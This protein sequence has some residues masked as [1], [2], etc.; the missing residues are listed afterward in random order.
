MTIDR[1]EFDSLS[2]SDLEELTEAQVP[3]GLRLEYKRELYGN[4]DSDKREFLKDVTALAN[5][6]GGH[7]ILG[8]EEK[9]I[10]FSFN[11]CAEFLKT[12]SGLTKCSRTSP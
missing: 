7:L 6:H 10:P 4:S 5:S 9:I 12:S 1:G 3:E 2:Q 8:I 11:R